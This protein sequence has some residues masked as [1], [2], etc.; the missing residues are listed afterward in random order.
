MKKKIFFSL[1]SIINTAYIIAQSNLVPNPSFE[2][3]S[4]C[5]NTNIT[6]APPWTGPT[7]NSTDY[8]NA[9]DVSCGGP[10]CGS[11]AY[12]YARTGNAYAGF[13]GV[14]GIGSNYREYAEVQLLNSLVIGRCY[15]IE[16]YTNL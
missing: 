13:W 11:K 12:Q 4:D 5:S 6:N 10:R 9:C 8:L 14:D 3:H 2:T 1:L 15:Y 16:F 7:T